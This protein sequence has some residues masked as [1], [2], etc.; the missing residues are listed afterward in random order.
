MDSAVS[1][2]F[3]V[4][5]P[6]GEKA[7]FTIFL[8]AILFLATAFP[9]SSQPGNCLPSAKK[10]IRSVWGESPDAVSV[11]KNTYSFLKGLNR[12]QLVFDSQ[13][14]VTSAEVIALSLFERTVF[15]K[16]ISLI[17]FWSP[18]SGIDENNF[19]D[20]INLQKQFSG[21]KELQILLLADPL[22]NKKIVN[23]R[24]RQAGLAGIEDT[25]K[26]LMQ[27]YTAQQ[28]A[29]GGIITL[30]GD[31]TNLASELP[32]CQFPLVLVWDNSGQITQLRE[33]IGDFPAGEIAAF[34]RKV[35]NN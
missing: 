11:Q 26:H 24:L 34:L 16:K 17:I 2:K 5:M 28:P 10:S 23:V 29:G 6:G 14:R 8:P 19:I 33:W 31:D 12:H 21:V 22:A 4:H 7:F 3:F 1:L 13:C 27:K 30:Y 35:I 9:L 15:E 32:L 18:N 25:K 20:V